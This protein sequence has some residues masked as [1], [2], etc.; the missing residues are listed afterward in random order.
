MSREA[1]GEGGA[2]M[3]SASMEAKRAIWCTKLRLGL[4]GSVEGRVSVEV[5]M[6]S[7]VCRGGGV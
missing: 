3:V 7:A 2:E 1:E 6:C 4:C 5:E